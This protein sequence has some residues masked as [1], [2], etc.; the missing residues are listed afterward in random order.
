M[1]HLY[2]P[3]RCALCKKL[4]R[5]PVHTVAEPLPLWRRLLSLAWPR[6][7][8]GDPAGRHAFFSK[9]NRVMQSNE[10]HKLRM[11]IRKNRSSK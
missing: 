5:H 1:S 6:W 9:H 8:W 11:Q 3:D 10:M 2:R 4:Q 7:M